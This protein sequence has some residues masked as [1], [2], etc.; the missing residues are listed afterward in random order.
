VK[1]LSENIYISYLS[2]YQIKTPIPIA[3]SKIIIIPEKNFEKKNC[4]FSS[5]K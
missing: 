5:Y 3:K 1:S 4:I 2:I